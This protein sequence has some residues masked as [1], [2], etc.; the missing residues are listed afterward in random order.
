M[1]DLHPQFVTD[2]T[3]KQVS[4]ILPIQEYNEV[5]KELETL[6]EAYDVELYKK[7]RQEDVGER[8]SLSDYIEKRKQKNG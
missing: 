5:M 3:G 2:S 7:A 6:E 4:V 8:I 1:N